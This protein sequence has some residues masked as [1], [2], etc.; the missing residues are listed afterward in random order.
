MPLSNKAPSPRPWGDTISIRLVPIKASVTE[1]FKAPKNSG[2]VLGRAIFQK[3]VDCDAPRDRRISR[4]SGSSVD[5]PMETDTAM[6]KKLMMNAISTV[7]KSCAPTN[8]SATIG[9][10]VAL[11]T[12]LNP[13]S[14]G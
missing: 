5:S 1:T 8:I 4:Y 2:N 13:T 6:G 9:T 3:I 14:S 7:L 12:A 11:G 10:T